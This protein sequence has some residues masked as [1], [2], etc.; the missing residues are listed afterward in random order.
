MSIDDNFEDSNRGPD[1]DFDNSSFPSDSDREFADSISFDMT[2]GGLYNNGYHV[3]WND[4]KERVMRLKLSEWIGSFSNGYPTVDKNSLLRSIDPELELP[5]DHPIMENIRALPEGTVFDGYDAITKFFIDMGYDDFPSHMPHDYLSRNYVPTDEDILNGKRKL[6]NDAIE[7]GDADPLSSS[8]VAL[9]NDI[10]ELERKLH[11]DLANLAGVN[12]EDAELAN[13]ENDS[14]E[15]PEK[16]IDMNDPLRMAFYA[17][18]SEKVKNNELPPA[19]YAYDS[20]VNPE[21]LVKKYVDDANKAKVDSADSINSVPKAEDINHPNDE[22][23]D[24]SASNGKGSKEAN[25]E[26]GPLSLGNRKPHAKGGSAATKARPYPN[27]H[28]HEDNAETIISKLIMFGGVLPFRVAGAAFNRFGPGSEAKRINHFAV[29][30]SHHINKS[31]KEILENIQFMGSGLN[32]RAVPLQSGEKEEFQKQIAGQI[33]DFHNRIKEGEDL[34]KNSSIRPEVKDELLKSISSGGDLMK[35]ISES[36]N[37]DVEK[38]KEMA[39]EMIK[40]IMEIINAIF[41][42]GKESGAAPSAG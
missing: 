19:N 28:H 36:K 41:G 16:N 37:K 1:E 14:A 7:S 40:K 3:V 12:S 17:L 34:L 15:D 24:E 30:K 21:D 2:N 6:Y 9:K 10:D 11:P 35:S 38:I 20:K 33:R 23:N 18:I 39:I 13:G 8:M 22:T 5:F 25:A 31:G 32:S 27:T 29:A 4:E 42:R 26:G